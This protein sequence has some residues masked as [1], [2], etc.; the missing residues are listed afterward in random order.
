MGSCDLTPSDTDF[1]CRNIAVAFD[2]SSLVVTPLAE[3][4]MPGEQSVAWPFVSDGGRGSEARPAADGGKPVWGR[5]ESAGSSG[6]L[7]VL[8]PANSADCSSA[9]CC[10]DPNHQRQKSKD[11]A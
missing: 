3:A 1:R 5:D 8:R 9:C 11:C 7:E 6:L 10:T 4:L 2:E